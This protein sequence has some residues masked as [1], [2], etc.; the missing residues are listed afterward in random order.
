[1]KKDKDLRVGLISQAPFP[2]GNVSTMRY[3]SYMK[4]LANNGT[5]SYVLIYCP[6]RMAAHIKQASGTYD[7]IEFQY[8]T[9]ITWKK[10]NLLNK[11]YYLFKGLFNSISYLNSKNLSTLILYGDNSFTVTLFYWLYTRL[12]KKRFIGDRSE[13]PSKNERKSKSKMFIYGLK[14]K[15]FD[16]MIIMTKQLMK[17]YSQYSKRDDFLFFLPMTIDPTRFDGLQKEKQDKPYIAVVFGTH[18]RDGLLETLMSFDLYCKKGGQYDLWLIGDYENMPNKRE[19]DVQYESSKNKE[20]IH[21]LGKLPNDSVP[22]VLYNASM[23]LTTP[24]LY[25]SGGF[26]TKLGEYMLSGVPIVATKVGELL[27]YIE[28]NVDMLM[29]NP[30]DYE[31]ISNN[32]LVLERDV[33]FAHK[34][35]INARKKAQKVFCANS[36]IETLSSFLLE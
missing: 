3:S 34:L 17:F 25:V 32:L 20:R 31:S 10:Y 15:M 33:S 29:S 19:L 28:P 7:N 12:T 16:G 5:Y 1:M 14:Q 13:L 26:P 35:S 23:L 24:N 11:V 18:N 9:L 22:K 21:I 4:T 36:Y 8:S 2:I 27:D 6:T 30:K